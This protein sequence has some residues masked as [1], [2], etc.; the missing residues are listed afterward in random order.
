MSSTF[1]ARVQFLDDT[2]P[3]SSTSYPEPSRPPSFTFLMNVHLVNQLSGIHKLLSP[4]HKLEDCALQLCKH[5]SLGQGDYGIYLDLESTLDDQQEELEGFNEQRKNT[6]ILRT[7]LSV[8]VHAIIEK[9]IN[10]EGRELRRALFSLKQIFQDDKDLVHEFVCSDGLDCLI[11]VGTE[12]WE[13]QNHQNYILRALGQVML[14]VDGMNGV[15]SHP[16]TVQWL[17]NLLSSKFRLVLKTALKL[18]LVYV[19][20]TEKNSH[21]L[22]ECIQ[23]I[24]NDKRVPPFQGVVDILNEKHGG[25]S[26]LCLFAMTL[27]NKI[28]NGIADQDTFYDITDYLEEQGMEAIIR[29]HMARSS[30]DLDLI[31]QLNLYEAALKA[32]DGDAVEAS[33]IRKAPRLKSE[34]DTRKSRRSKGG[35]ESSSSPVTLRKPSVIEEEP[36][37][38]TPGKIKTDA[39]ESKESS[40]AEPMSYLEKRRAQRAAMKEKEGEEG[41]QKSR[42]G[43][44]YSSRKGATQMT[45]E[46]GEVQPVESGKPLSVSEGS[47]HEPDDRAPVIDERHLNKKLANDEQGSRDSGYNSWRSDRS[48]KKELDMKSPT[49]PGVMSNNRRWMLYKMT[50]Q[51]ADELK[52]LPTP[53]EQ[54]QVTED[55]STR[56]DKLNEPAALGVDHESSVVKPGK[57][58]ARSSLVADKEPVL[59]VTSQN[60]QLV[61]GNKN[62]TELR[63]KLANNQVSRTMLTP[64]L[65]V[66]VSSTSIPS[67]PDPDSRWEGIERAAKK[68]ALKINDLDFTDLKDIDDVNVLQEAPIQFTGQAPPPPMGGPPMPPP[69]GGPPMPPPPFPGGVPPPPSMMAPPPPGATLPPK[70]GLKKTDNGSAGS[71]P[72]KTI[73][74]HWKEVRDK[75]VIPNPTADIKNKG[76]IWQ[77]CKSTAID[78]QKF[79]HLF[80]TRVVDQKAKKQTDG[81]KKIITVLDSKRSNAINIGLTKLPPA[82][83]IKAAILKMDSTIINREGIEKLLTTMVPTDEE[84]QKI[85]DAQVQNPDIPLGNAEQLLLTMSSISELEARLQLWAFK[86]DYDTN[87][88]EIAEPLSDLKEGIVALHESKTFK[89][90]LSVLLSIGNFLNGANASGFHID[91]LSKVPEV[92][93]TVHKHSL[94]HHLCV[95]VSEL[96]TDSTD[97]YSEISA[98]A[99]CAKVDWDELKDKLK[100]LEE[101]CRKA[102]DNLRLVAK[103]ETYSSNNLKVKLS[104]FLSDCAERI[105]I[106]KIVHQRVI[107]RF[108]KL[109][110]FLGIGATD[111]K[112]TKVH[113]FCK[114]VSEFALEY[115]TTREKVLTQHAKKKS[116]KERKK[117]RGKLI[118]DTNNFGKSTKEV[119]QEEQMLTSLL[120]NGKTSETLPRKKKENA[121]LN[122]AKR[123]SLNMPSG[124][125]AE[126]TGDELLESA[127]RSAATAGPRMRGERKRSQYRHRKSLRRTLKGELVD[128]EG[129]NVEEIVF[130][131]STKQP[132]STKMTDKDSRPPRF[133]K[134]VSER[135]KHIAS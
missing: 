116:Y 130:V 33:D 9:L 40:P 30:A 56:I 12:A 110:L 70:T 55:L 13:D 101:E 126:D 78:A 32:E 64:K 75:V 2:D 112:E 85:L 35:K 74:L 54:P 109:L 84:R 1:V 29:R 24:D 128:E 125:E 25:D 51:S 90:I 92:K 87:E 61:T 42:P 11:K 97:L 69:I 47:L 127:F 120:S 80:E 15:I 91:Y 65:P 36:S 118:V 63:D 113:T 20:Y 117:T 96:Y 38:P 82:R 68:R 93:D 39:F 88:K 100:K 27:V 59:S 5:N 66:A 106:L 119:N 46:N 53:K 98:I 83:T 102:M 19:E 31:S 49:T 60:G 50:K 121:H 6:I 104:E 133:R 67:Q 41:R 111:C 123:S 129:N 4:P 8:R 76:T 108:Y 7:Q 77:K 22:Y 105:V 135:Y 37:K 107:H 10:S 23:E 48:E 62:V 18:L 89:Y 16:Q 79:E 131:Q 99:R 124:T 94:L 86:L 3:F 43:R 132:E 14:Y 26:E 95:T 28:L 114:N 71:K 103:H 34:G 58:D 81:S 134:G 17:Y 52:D 122:V 115:R 45:V 72:R 57:L 44:A 21:R 73:R